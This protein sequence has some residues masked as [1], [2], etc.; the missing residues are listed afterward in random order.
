[1]MQSIYNTD[2]SFFKEIDQSIRRNCHKLQDVQTYL[3]QFQTLSQDLLML[4]GNLMKFKLRLPSFFKN[5]IYSMTEKTVNDIFNKKRFY[6]AWSDENC[7]G[8]T[9]NKQTIRILAKV[10]YRLCLSSS[11]ACKEGI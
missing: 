1:M 8:N 6:R 5:A 11:D 3:F 7:G 2:D 4:T 9:P 10:D